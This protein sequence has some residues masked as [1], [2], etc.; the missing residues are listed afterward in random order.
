MKLRIVPLQEVDPG[1]R[2]S[3]Q[4]LAGSALEPNPFFEPAAL[5]PA[6]ALLAG[7]SRAGL[8]V[9]QDRGELLF[10]MPV[11]RRQRY[12]RVPVR[13]L[14][15]WHHPYSF[16]G[17]PLVC[18]GREHDAW[19]EVLDH[20][21]YRPEEPWLVLEQLSL[22]GPVAVALQDVL[23]DRHTPGTAVDIFSRPVLRRRPKPTYLEGRISARHR[24]ALRRQRRRLAEVLTAPVVLRDRAGSVTAELSRAVEGLL[25]MECAGWK[26]RTGTA[27]A[28]RPADAEFFHRLC[29]G[30]NAQGR[31]QLFSLGTDD[32][33]AAY[34]SNLVA[35]GVVFHYRVAYDEQLSAASPGLQLELDMVEQFHSDTRLARMDSCADRHNQ[36]SA[37]LFPDREALGVLLVPAR[38]GRGRAAV[39]AAST[40]I[41]TRAAA[42]TTL[43]AGRS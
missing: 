8:L 12:R 20:L 41:A 26:G 14:T 35:G 42:R 31:L 23:L 39:Q 17:T 37:H 11:Q 38:G 3:W 34:Q 29:S 43:L 10:V 2:E 9:V 21:R 13:A 19:A 33:A 27:L 18:P 1:L 22:H 24:K 36:D 5:E 30:F 28:C 16:L 32:R 25:A 7:G 15:A 40:L 6:G 4:A